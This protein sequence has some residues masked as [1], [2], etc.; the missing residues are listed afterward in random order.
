[1]I[2][3]GGCVA[4]TVIDV[5][6]NAVRIEGLRVRGGSYHEVDFSF[7]VGGV[8]T[9][10]IL[11]DTCDALYGVNVFAT[12]GGMSVTDDVTAGF[13]DA[14]IYIGGISTTGAK[15]VSV[16]GNRSLAN[17]RGIIVEDSVAAANVEVSGNRTKAN[18]AAGESVLNAGIFLHNADGVLVEG[19]L[20]RRN[21]DRG[22]ELDANSSGNVVTNNTISGHTFDLSNLG[23][24]NCFSGNI[25]ATSNGPLPAC[26]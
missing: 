18:R 5:N 16:M 19:N 17:N 12:N 24:S 1:V 7:V 11:R 13:G 15:H 9:G 8:I 3:D 4:L 10:S 26:L 21:G 20:V 25:Y 2:V 6:A 22:I 14:G 23:S